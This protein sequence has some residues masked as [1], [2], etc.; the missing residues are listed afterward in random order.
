MPVEHQ[1]GF[2]LIE[3]MIV[4]AVIGILAA[5]AVPQYEDYVSR[6]KI[7]EALTAIG[8][9]KMETTLYHSQHGVFPHQ[10][11]AGEAAL[12]KL[13]LEKTSIQSQ[14]VLGIDIAFAGPYARQIGGFV[15]TAKDSISLIIKLNPRT[16]PKRYDMKN[17]QYNQITLVGVAKNGGIFQWYCGP[18][19]AA[20]GVPSAILPATCRDFS[21]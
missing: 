17:W 16:F 18:R 13:G 7:T 12:T 1:H 4:V 20:F 15:G 21:W 3:L 11:G 2:A 5:I 6:A 14:Y 10:G 9:L 8:P 19:D